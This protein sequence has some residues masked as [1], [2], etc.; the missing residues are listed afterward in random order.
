MVLRTSLVLVV[1]IWSLEVAVLQSQKVNNEQK[2][3]C[4]LKGS[5]VDLPCS[6]RD[7]SGV[8]VTP[9]NW[10]TRWDSG[11]DAVD[12]SQNPKYTGRVEYRRDENSD[13]T[14]T[15]K[16]LRRT[17]SAE[18]LFRFN[19]EWDDS[20]GKDIPGTI[21]T[22]TDLQVEV[23]PA[24]VRK[25]QW[26]TLTCSTTCFL[27]GN[28]SYIWYKNGLH[29]S[30]VTKI[31]TVPEVDVKSY[32]SNSYSC[33]VKDQEDLHSPVVCVMGGH[34]NRVNYS[35]RKICA[36]IGSSVDISCTYYSH[37]TIK[38]QLWFIPQQSK[39]LH[40]DPEY[41]DRVTN[42]TES[43]LSTLR[44]MKLRQSDSVEYRFRFKTEKW[45][46]WG[47]DFPGTIL[48]VTDLQVKV[49]PTVVTEGQR[50]TLTC[51][52]TC[53]LTGDPS[54]IWY[55]NGQSLTSSQ[56]G[57]FDLDQASIEDAGNYSCSVSPL[58][59]SVVTIEVRY[60]PKN[61][62]IFVNSHGDIVEGRSVT[63]TCS[64]DANPPMVKYT[65]YKENV[66][67]SKGENYT[68]MN[69]CSEHSGGYY[70]E[71]QN[72]VGLAN[73]T[74]YMV[75]VFNQSPFKK[76]VI[77]IITI[78]GLTLTFLLVLPVSL[79]LCKRKT[80]N[81]SSIVQDSLHYANI[82]F[83]RPKNQEEVQYSTVQSSQIQNQ[84]GE[85]EYSILRFPSPSAAPRAQSPEDSSAIYS[86]VN[87]ART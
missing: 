38:S 40:L 31:T 10:Y 53:P 66:T 21:L 50:V 55:K 64:S 69:I 82:Q 8:T 25:G 5:S 56:T 4:V 12:L 37:Y 3:I 33:A 42:Y 48:T 63:L 76:S 87:K 6:Y 62:T 35:K 9:T 72:E 17:D 1:L 81:P 16:N 78:V 7:P 26:V 27:T 46:Y 51:S 73:S 32:P 74:T 2:K 59:S 23:T 49:T 30:V 86:T 77:V 47:E 18:Y 84:D 14:L 20:W 68:I 80:S 79:W 58:Q 36:L 22:V 39:E 65:W 71:A 54:Y 24:V 75:P 70:C 61:V 67:I 52:T 34:C 83:S 13:C 45:Y 57:Y 28:P 41:A 15:I 29:L 43:R 44:I 19:T 60:K 11:A 85:V